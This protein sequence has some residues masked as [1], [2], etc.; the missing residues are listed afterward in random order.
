M[1]NITAPSAEIVRKLSNVTP[2]MMGMEDDSDVVFFIN[3]TILPDVTGRVDVSADTASDPYDF[4]LAQSVWEAAY[5]DLTGGEISE[6]MERQEALFHQAILS[7]SV[8][9]VHLAVRRPASASFASEGS[10]SKAAE[11]RTNGEAS[12]KSAVESVSRIIARATGRPASSTGA[13]SFSVSP[14]EQTATVATSTGA[15]INEIFYP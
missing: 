3:Q 1:A 11:Y 4:P 2:A 6:R 14:V 12:L 10:M 5:P 7:L 15:V 9:G 8:A 13:T